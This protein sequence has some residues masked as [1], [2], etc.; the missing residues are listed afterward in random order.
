MKLSKNFSLEEFLCPCGCAG[1]GD[2]PMQVGF[3]MKLQAMRDRVRV[4]FHI[5]SG[6]RCKSHNEKIGG[7]KSSYHM[8]GRAADIACDNSVD[9]YRL[10][11][12][13]IDAGF[14]GIGVNRGFIHVDD[15]NG[16]SASVM[17]LYG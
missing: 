1:I 14:K 3:I 5:T 6:Y 8:L 11:W 2:L 12:A 13:A 17:F 10:V 4:P 9:R 16:D 7:A 15:R